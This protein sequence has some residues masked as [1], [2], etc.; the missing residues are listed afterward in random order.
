MGISDDMSF[1]EWFD[2]FMDETKKLGYH[3]SIDKYTFES[4][5]ENDKTP[6]LTAKE[7]VNETNS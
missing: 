3:G 7:F 6:E 2:I 1:D 4:D 5:Y